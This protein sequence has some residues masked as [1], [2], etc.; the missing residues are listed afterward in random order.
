MYNKYMCVRKVREK[1]PTVLKLFNM[2]KRSGTHK[3]G[4]QTEM[5]MRCEVYPMYK[6]TVLYIKNNVDVTVYMFLT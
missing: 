5:R 4:I 2:M 6:T 3:A 1:G